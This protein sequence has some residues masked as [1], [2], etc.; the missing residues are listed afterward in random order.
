MCLDGHCFCELPRQ[1]Q[2]GGCVDLSSDPV[3]CGACGH[4]CAPGEGCTSPNAANLCPGVCQP[5]GTFPCTS[6]DYNNPDFCAVG[7]VFCKDGAEICLELYQGLFNILQG[8]CGTPST[9]SCPCSGG[10]LSPD[11][12]YLSCTC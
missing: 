11:G 9:T 1:L 4:A 7:M 10:M 6:V 8:S 2:C 12:H 3:N 5:P